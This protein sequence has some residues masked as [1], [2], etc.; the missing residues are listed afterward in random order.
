MA[1]VG[2]KLD[3]QR[4]PLFEYWRV[5]CT[6]KSPIFQIVE[7]CVGAMSPAGKQRSY[8]KKYGRALA[9]CPLLVALAAPRC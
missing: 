8:V 1:S 5:S 7:S 9:W 3:T 2:R 6:C 4:T